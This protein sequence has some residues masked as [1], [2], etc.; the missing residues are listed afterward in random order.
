MLHKP[1]FHKGGGGVTVVFV[2]QVSQKSK[3]PVVE[4]ENIPEGVWRKNKWEMKVF[5]IFILCL[6]VQEE[7]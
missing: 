4:S 1:G 7:Q 2:W 3:H 6:G 5:L